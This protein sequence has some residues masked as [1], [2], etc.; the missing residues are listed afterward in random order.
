MLQL[1]AGSCK[2]HCSQHSALL[3]WQAKACAANVLRRCARED[4]RYCHPGLCYFTNGASKC[5]YKAVMCAVCTGV[6]RNEHFDKLQAGYLFP[7]V[8][9]HEPASAPDYQGITSHQV[10]KP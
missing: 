6:K 1:N 10:C 5:T 7:E 9:P 4:A 8:G 2:L 3:S